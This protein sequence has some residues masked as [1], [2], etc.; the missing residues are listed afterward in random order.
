MPDAMVVPIGMPGG[1][2]MDVLC[3]ET[4]FAKQK[5][6]VSRRQAEARS[7]LDIFGK[8]SLSGPE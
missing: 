5:A 6:D 7:M 4:E 3:A 8:G 2:P 1:V